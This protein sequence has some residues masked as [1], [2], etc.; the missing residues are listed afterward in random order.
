MNVTLKPLFE[1]FV[2]RKLEAGDFRSADEVV[3]EASRLLQQQDEQWAVE[4][5]A[6][7]DEGWG[8]AKSRKLRDPEAEREN[9]TARKTA[10]TAELSAMAADPEVQ[11]ELRGVYPDIGCQSA[12]LPQRRVR[13]KVSP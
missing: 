12:C 6:K 2:R 5:R 13:A 1:E 7:I 11:R 4:A 3:S 9:L 10:W 8:Q